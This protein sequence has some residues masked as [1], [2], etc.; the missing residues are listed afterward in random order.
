MPSTLERLITIG[1]I[2]RRTGKD[3]HRVEYVI[4]ARGIKPRGMAG[5]ARVFDDDQVERIAAALRG[6]DERR[7]GR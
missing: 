6:I 2:S 5:N 3:I 4:R 1:E 7:D